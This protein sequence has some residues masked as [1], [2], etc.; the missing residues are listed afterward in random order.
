LKAIDWYQVFVIK[1]FNQNHREV[2][3]NDSCLIKC[4][5]IGFRFLRYKFHP[6]IALVT[7]PIHLLMASGSDRT[8]AEIS[9]MS[10]VSKIDFAGVYGLLN[11]LL[12]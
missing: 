5:F 2:G 4:S 1:R 11:D 3:V 6:W 9:W 7:S 12:W 10:A 8:R